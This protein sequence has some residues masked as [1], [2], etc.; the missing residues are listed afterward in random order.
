MRA[1]NTLNLSYGS[2]YT[3][4]SY[5]DSCYSTIDYMCIPVE[6]CDL[7]VH[8]EVADD[9]YLNMYRHKPI[10]CCLNIPIYCTEHDD[11]HVRCFWRRTEVRAYY[12]MGIYFS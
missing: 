9:I 7:V 1:V 2:L 4:V 5:D 11:A 6:I 12:G 10:L 8:C 3:Y